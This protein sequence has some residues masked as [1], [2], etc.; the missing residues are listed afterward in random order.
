[1][2]YASSQSLCGCI[3][4][5]LLEPKEDVWIKWEVCAEHYT[6]EDD[7]KIVEAARNLREHERQLKHATRF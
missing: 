5:R 1:M 6:P 3:K 4:T 2:G 7:A